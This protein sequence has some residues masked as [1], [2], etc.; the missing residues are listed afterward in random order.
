MTI[1]REGAPIED[2][3]EQWPPKRRRRNRS[4]DVI[5]NEKKD[6]ALEKRYPEKSE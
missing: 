2:V 5:K 6:E 1:H 4:A 3:G